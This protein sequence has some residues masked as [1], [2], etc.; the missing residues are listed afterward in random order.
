MF[1]LQQLPIDGAW[2]IRGIAHEDDRGSFHEWFKFSELERKANLD[3]D[4]KQANV[5]KS[6]QGVVRG[7]HFSKSTYTQSKLITCL[8]GSIF[9]VVVDLRA[10]S[11]TFGRWCSYELSDRKNEAVLISHGLGHA[12]QSL[13]NETIVTYLQTSEYEPQNEYAINPMDVD[14]NINW[15]I[16]KKITSKRDAEAKGLNSFFKVPVEIQAEQGA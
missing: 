2:L 6:I 15:P 12:F 13:E 8:K 5:S 9:D 1:E 11:N 3:F 7:I 14:I 4:V 16:E 10:G